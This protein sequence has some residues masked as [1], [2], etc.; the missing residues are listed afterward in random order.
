MATL[1]INGID[2]EITDY[3]FFGGVSLFRPLRG[4]DFPKQLILLEKLFCPPKTL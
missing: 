2:E 4:A 1:S 3:N